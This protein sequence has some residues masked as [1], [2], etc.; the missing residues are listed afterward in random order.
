[1]DPNPL[2]TMNKQLWRLAIILL[3]CGTGCIVYEEPPRPRR[4]VIYRETVAPAS[5]PE[6]LPE[7]SPEEVE[8]NDGAAEVPS[9]APSRS[10]QAAS[11]PRAATAPTGGPRTGGSMPPAA[12]NLGRAARARIGVQTMSI[13][14]EMHYIRTDI[15]KLVILTAICIAVLIALSFVVPSI[16][17]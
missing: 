16:V 7:A 9:Y 6:A 13:P 5:V 8:V 2:R 4:R 3:L 17:K 10:Q 14:E 15:R 12:R 1:M 11:R